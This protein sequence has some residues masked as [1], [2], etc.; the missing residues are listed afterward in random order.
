[1]LQPS[2]Y[3]WDAPGV[4]AILRLGFWRQ[5]LEQLCQNYWKG[6]HLV[7]RLLSSSLLRDETLSSSEAWTAYQ[8]RD[9]V[10][11]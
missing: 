8:S 3:R 1:M 9:E 7:L 2:G 6:C 4:M 10:P 5:A 11:S